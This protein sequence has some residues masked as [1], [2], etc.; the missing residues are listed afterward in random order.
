MCS[1]WN[2][3]FS[4]LE[5]VGTSSPTNG[6]TCNLHAICG[7]SLVAGD[8]CRLV[9]CS[10]T[11]N[12]VD[13]EAIK[14]V[15]VVDGMETCMVGYVPRSF[16]AMEKVYAHASIGGC[17]VINKIYKDCNNDYKKQLANRNKGMASTSLVD[18][19]FM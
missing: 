17:I 11:I 3:A 1:T 12:N 2:H 5:I 14:V 8:I 7:D 16:A 19:E 15:K 6:R 4:D 18:E 10:V 13:E 9:P